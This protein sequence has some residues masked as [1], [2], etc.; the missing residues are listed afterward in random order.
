M[1]GDVIPTLN[2]AGRST[3]RQALLREWLPN[4]KRAG[5]LVTPKNLFPVNCAKKPNKGVVGRHA[6][7][8]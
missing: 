8:R 3:E 5:I 7:F 1:P 6:S 2:E 4:A